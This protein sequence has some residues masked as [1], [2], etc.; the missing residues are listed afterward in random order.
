MSR[1]P[2]RPLDG[3]G[4]ITVKIG[5]LVTLSILAAVVVSEVGDRAGVSAWLSIP[6][7]VAAALF[8]TQWLARGMT[9]PLRQMTVAA[10]RMAGGDYSTRIAASA[11][12][13]VGQLGTAF[14]T[15]SAELEGADRQR[16]ELLATV[17]HE[18]RTPLAAQRALLENLVDGV[19]TPDDRSLQTALEQSERLSA[20][21][22]DLL[23][24]SRVEAGVATLDFEP[25]QVADL[26]ARCAEE[27]R[28]VVA[29][30]GHAVSVEVD[31]PEDLQARVDRARLTQAVTN[32]LDNAVRHSPES[33]TVRVV[34]RADGSGWSLAVGDEGPG[35]P[36]GRSEEMFARFGVGDD[37][38]GGTGLGLSIV[39]WV[40][41][42]HGGTVRA[43]EEGPGSTTTGAVVRVELPLAP[44]EYRHGQR[45]AAPAAQEVVPRT[46][47]RTTDDREESPMTTHDSPP[48]PA[49]RTAD[50]TGT[51]DAPAATPIPVPTPSVF[52]TLFGRLWPEPTS[53]LHTAP[54]ALWASVGTGALA[55]V[56]LPHR[57]IGIAYAL[58]LLAAGAL[59]LR[60]SRRRRDPWTL[61]S[62]AL[63]V[64]LASLL[65]IR[66]AEWLS[67]LALLTAAL[68]VTT[69][70]T[71]ARGVPAMVA[72]AAAW[73]LSGLRG[74][75]LLGRTITATSRH[76]LLWPVVRTAAISL[77]ALVVFGGL[78]AS[79]DAVVGAWVSDLLP[80]VDIAESLVLR[81]F[82]WFVVGGIV[83]AACYLSLNPPRTD[84]VALPE[85]PRPARAWEWVV[86]VGVVV[87]TFV[88]FL[89]AQGAAMF[90]GHDFVQRA[91]GMTY[92][93]SVHQG[94]GQLTLATALTLVTVVI[95][96]RRASRKTP[97][98]R[99]LL[100]S[101]LGMLCGLTLVVVGS[102]LYRM[103][104]YQEAYGFTVLRVMVDAFELWLGLLVVL[105]MVAGWRLRG[106]WVPR[107]ALASG[108][109]FLLVIGLANPEGWVAQRNI[110]RYA[111]TGRLDLIYLQT[112]GADAV[113]TIRAGLAGE[114]AVG[115]DNGV[116]LA[117]CAIG[118]IPDDELTE[119]AL[120]W[121][122]GRSRADAAGP[123]SLTPVDGYSYPTFA[124]GSCP[125][126]VG[127]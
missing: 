99:V 42:L 37:A 84:L 111:E 19:V 21:V 97:R 103:H 11:S 57:G 83:L 91:T 123:R 38:G 104:V 93:E 108:A 5:V 45:E 64:G 66:A 58:V 34:A 8:V 33:G 98:D 78:F 117:D 80:E 2:E 74:L 107:A 114:T 90:G 86:P 118:W 28:A 32:L 85:P 36:P 106:G 75:P 63:C 62:A 20:L 88:V 16:R 6:V 51:A 18:L 12:D 7:S 95:V 81:S 61:A 124:V 48:L 67:V 49:Q 112:L 25:V 127:P 77:V 105:V 94:F 110:D 30:R 47:G 40:C 54:L 96:G 10:G 46:T 72:G 59:V 3:V 53:R 22:Q 15:M 125:V 121:N 4:S 43:L 70:L 50:D 69:A 14:N 13:E 65:V 29:A 26:L 60:L 68:L 87:A 24:L 115:A 76:T 120:G 126:E 113:P 92:A 56:L 9:A 1:A 44:P 23:D 41:E 55:A 122:L 31:A 82:T 119:D 102:A 100:R 52:D 73:V 39:R 35:F 79:G 17:S 89:L 116:T 109:T 71:G 101:V 27:A